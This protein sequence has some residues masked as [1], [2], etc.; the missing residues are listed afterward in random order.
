MRTSTTGQN[1]K[2]WTQLYSKWVHGDTAG[3]G[4]ELSLV[5][6][7]PRTWILGPQ[8]EDTGW[9]TKSLFRRTLCTVAWVGIPK[10]TFCE[11]QEW[12][13]QYRGREAGLSGRDYRRRRAG[14]GGLCCRTG[15]YGSKC[16]FWCRQVKTCGHVCVSTD[17]FCSVCRGPQTQVWVSKHHP[18]LRGTW[19]SLEK[20]LLPGLRKYM[21]NT[22]YL[23]V[24]GRKQPKN[25]A[26]RSR[27]GG[28][29]GHTWDSLRI[30]TK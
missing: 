28:L 30:K 6:S 23:L 12:T 20:Q 26:H 22:Q 19:D 5:T 13:C 17:A 4:E 3:D 29:P 27:P 18:P 16:V 14:A 7:E 10:T 25:G 15:K 8:P 21:V 1:R 11:F 24:P 2:K 9:T